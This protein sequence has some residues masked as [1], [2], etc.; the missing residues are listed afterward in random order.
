MSIN[1]PIV[2]I[3]PEMGEG[4]FW[5]GSICVPKEDI[6]WC[7]SGTKEEVIEYY[8]KEFPFL[9]I[10]DV[11]KEA[12]ALARLGEAIGNTYREEIREEEEFRRWCRENRI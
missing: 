2:E 12:Y 11:S 1:K 6:G 8:Q 3:H 7:V 9:E 10:V 4:A 5:V